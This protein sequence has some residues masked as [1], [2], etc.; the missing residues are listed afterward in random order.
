MKIYIVR[1]NYHSVEV[2]INKKDAEKRVKH[3]E[4]CAGCE[5]SNEMFWITEL[6]TPSIKSKWEE[7][8][9]EEVN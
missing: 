3:L 5:G 6:Y 1:G 2:Y 8:E 7:E 9:E 4:Y